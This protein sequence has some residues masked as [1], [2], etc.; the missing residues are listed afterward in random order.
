MPN[1]FFTTLSKY[2]QRDIVPM[3][4]PG[5][6]RNPLCTMSDPY[7]FDVTEVPG[8]DDLHHPEE[9]IRDLM[10]DLT[11]WYDSEQTYL[12]VNGSTCGILSAVTAC[13][14]PGDKILVARNCHKSVYNAIKLLG[15]R[16]V[17]VY[18]RRLEG[19]MGELGVAGEIEVSEVRRLLKE[20]PEVRCV[21]I[22]SPTYEGIVSD[23]A[24]IA[25]AVHE[26][27]IP[28]VVDEAHGA[29]FNWLPT[30]PETAV[31]QGADLVI[32]SLHK[33]L[34]AF[35]QTAVLHRTGNRIREDRLLWALQTYQSSSPSYVLMASI[36]KCFEYV[37]KEET[38]SSAH[39]V[40]NLN[41]FYEKVKNLQKLELVYCEG[42]DRSKIVV[43][44]ARTEL[45]GQQLEEILLEHYGIQLEMS[46][47]NYALGMATICDTAE[48]FSRFAA[49]LCDLDRSLSYAEKGAERTFTYDVKPP[50][51]RM[52]S[53]EAERL[54]LKEVP[55]AEAAG[56]TAAKD[57]YLYP[58][59]VPFAV[60]GEIFSQE[61]VDVLLD[62]Q[63]SGYEVRGVE[64]N[65]V[66]VCNDKV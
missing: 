65:N 57:V 8:V 23:I 13:C 61:M 60:A 58:P 66:F 26:K 20:N 40:K 38:F 32:E 31:R 43:S 50:E 49:A 44:T 27:N 28:L 42:M 25:E 7:S 10:D 14:Y 54:P 35:T 6:K 33:T 63:K 59:G 41:R 56:Q 48:N 21:M 47:G 17:Y 16:P 5:H 39:F 46:C 4:M 37:Q 15:L 3:H 2:C 34:P 45:T 11:K 53:Y 64:N 55:L 29:H 62:G 52:Y 24:G 51:Q 30:F 22:T 18:P 9:M 36:A 12:L 19:A 1:H